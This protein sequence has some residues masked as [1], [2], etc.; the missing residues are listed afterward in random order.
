MTNEPFDYLTADRDRWRKLATEAAEVLPCFCAMNSERQCVRC[1]INNAQIGI[2]SFKDVGPKSTLAAS[3]TNVNNYRLNLQTRLDAL[4]EWNERHPDHL[5]LEYERDADLW[6]E[7]KPDER[8]SLDY[9]STFNPDDQ[10]PNVSD[11]LTSQMF[12][13]IMHIACAAYVKSIGK[14]GTR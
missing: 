8:V 4:L 14:A 3:Y 6:H 2:V 10:P 7:A 5:T 11:I 13:D 9:C 1:Q 12:A